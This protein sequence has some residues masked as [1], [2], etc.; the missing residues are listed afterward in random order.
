[1]TIA[2]SEDTV[3]TIV[4]RIYMRPVTRFMSRPLITVPPTTP[5]WDA[6]EIIVTKRIRRLPIVEQGRLVGIVT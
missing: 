5:V 3:G 4:S 6:F 2:S 1:M